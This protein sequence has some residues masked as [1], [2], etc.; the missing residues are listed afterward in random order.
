MAGF[1]GGSRS[2]VNTAGNN[3]RNGCATH[4]DWRVIDDWRAAHRGV[5][6]TFQAILRTRTRGSRTV[7]GQRHK[8]RSTIVGKLK[9]FPSMQLS[10]MDDVAGCRLIFQTVSGLYEFRDNLHRARFKHRLKNDKE[11]YDY[12]EYPKSTGYRGVHDVY[13]YDVNSNAG[14]HLR[15]LLVEVQYRTEIQHAWATAVEVIGF[16]TQSQ[17][18]FQEGDRRYE[19]AMAWAAEILSRAFEGMTG[20]HP[21]KS[22]GE[23]V[24]RFLECEQE[25]GLLHMLRG[26]NLADTEVSQNRNTILIFTEEGELEVRTYRDSTD[27]LRALFE[28][29]E[30][31]GGG[32]I[33]LV[34]ADTSE[35]MR[36]AF[37]NYFSDARDFVELVERGCEELAGVQVSR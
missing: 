9:R 1:P 10:R 2:R 12:I 28:L 30:E 16:I 11:K 13:S 20:C 22:N 35:E 26:L 21:E 6:N 15:G 37:K 7:V 4:D 36:F 27:A 19:T 24:R 32:D 8:R 17:P 34:K 29:E 25:L 3:V 14:R 18:K 23:V 33:V 31:K 5:L